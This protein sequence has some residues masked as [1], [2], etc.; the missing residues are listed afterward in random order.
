MNLCSCLISYGASLLADSTLNDS[1]LPLLDGRRTIILD[2]TLLAFA[3]LCAFKLNADRVLI[4]LFDRKY[5][6]IIAEAT[7]ATAID[8]L[9]GSDPLSTV[10]ASNNVD[11][12][13]SGTAILRDHGICERVLDNPAVKTPGSTELPVLVVPDVTEDPQ[14]CSRPLLKTGSPFRSY[15]GIPLRTPGGIDIGVCAV[16]N[17]EPRTTWDK[18]QPQRLLRHLT[19]LV[20]SHLQARVSVEGARRSDRMVRGL[21]SMVEGTSSMSRWRDAANPQSFMDLQ[22]REGVLNAKQ[23]NIQAHGNMAQHLSTAAA[24]SSTKPS[25]DQQRENTQPDE[26][27][28]VDSNDILTSSTE[29]RSTELS[30]QDDESIALKSLFSRAANIIRESIEVEG[31]LFL[32]SATESYGA[33]V[34]KAA[35]TRSSS[36]SLSSTSSGEESVLTD[37]SAGE[38]NTCRVL[39]FSTSDSSSING[40]ERAPIYSWVPD[41]ILT[42][43]LRRYE[44]GQVFNFGEDGLVIGPI[45][46]SE[47]SDVQSSK[48]T[49]RSYASRPRKGDGLF[50]KSLLKGATSVAMV[51]LWDPQRERWFSAGF[52][53]TK[54]RSRV[55][56]IQDELSWLKAFGAATMAEVA[57]LEV[58]RENKAKE[59]VLGSLSHEIRSPLHGILLGV[60]LMHDSVMT[61]FQKD[62]VHTVETCGSTLLDTMDHL[63]DFSKVNHFLRS[64]KRKGARDK[65]RGMSNDTGPRTPIE[66]G[67]M[68]IYSDVS[69]NLL[70]EEV[71]ESVFAGFSFQERSAEWAA[72]ESDNE[73]YFDQRGTNRRLESVRSMDTAIRRLSPARSGS[74]SIV[75]T[76]ARV[77]VHISI[78]PSVSWAFHAQPGALR[79][80][81]MNIFGNALKYTS[82]GSILVSLK[83]ETLPPKRR[84]RRRT[85]VLCVSDSGQ[86]IT[87]DY[88]RNRLYTPFSQE[89]QL[90]AGAGLGLSIVKRIVHGLG[91]SIA[92]E[93]R[94]GHGTS[95]RVTFPLMLA[96]PGVSPNTTAPLQANTAFEQLLASLDGLSICLLGFPDRFG[97]PDRPLAI[98]DTST[99]GPKALLAGLC[100]KHLHL[101]VVSEDEARE[102]PPSFYLCVAT[103]QDKVVELDG[104][105][106]PSP[107]V[108]VCENALA[109][110]DLTASFAGSSSSAVREFVSQP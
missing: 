98:D 3:Q 77:S 28:A 96:S 12:L 84:S 1:A 39:G 2:A 74:P 88:L 22:G 87:P 24:T 58:I 62:I 97:E 40:D 47:E 65:G 86:G 63:L 18:D 4:S 49:R 78:D 57:R 80:I 81:V 105:V 25:S 71:V 38:T 106:L 53:W 15:A 9:S 46:D 101:T 23:Q 17:A 69:L 31:V 59:D 83:Q 89:N 51:P 70:L 20:M 64:P 95:V 67:M 6:Y 5:Q 79:R 27:V 54:S 48:A 107:T 90:S 11:L 10:P 42:R 34:S 102:T 109:A 36:R 92:V 94:V 52:V 19:K 99:T 16:F 41:T 8:L 76:A 43:L 91:G 13:F 30:Q 35:E 14:I 104:R 50:L 68:S 100:Q 75:A 61:G 44:R 72:K 108:V 82:R 60:E 26:E 7:Q 93:S 21:G 55:F 85:I 103:A 33:F 29:H 110:R 45:S 56:T 66:A 37:E 32:D 73:S